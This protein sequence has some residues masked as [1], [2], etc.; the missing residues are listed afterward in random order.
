[1]SPLRDRKAAWSDPKSQRPPEREICSWC[2]KVL[3]PEETLLLPPLSWL[4][5]CSPCSWRCSEQETSSH[6]DEL[7]AAFPPDPRLFLAGSFGCAPREFLCALGD[8]KA[9]PCAVHRHSLPA[10]SCMKS[11]GAL[12]S[13]CGNEKGAWKFPS[14]GITANNVE[15]LPSSTPLFYQL[16]LKPKV[17]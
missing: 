3:I 16:F 4:N 7:L 12:L 15:F 8:P 11:P 14:S 13:G 5:S 1:M 2:G 10:P 17:A 6:R 9:P